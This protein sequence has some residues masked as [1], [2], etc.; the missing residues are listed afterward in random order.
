ML[1]K[2]VSLPI[3][4]HILVMEDILITYILHWEK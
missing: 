4:F 2:K 1:K 3:L